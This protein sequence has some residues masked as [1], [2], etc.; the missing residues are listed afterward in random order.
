MI[1]LLVVSDSH[2]RY[3][4]LEEVLARQ[5]KLPESFRPTHLLHLGDGVNDVEKCHLAERMCTCLVKGNCDG[6]F[7]NPPVPNERVLELGGIKILMMHGH[8]RG[9]KGGDLN[10]VSYA[11]SIGADILLFGH[12]HTPVSYTLEKG[13]DLGETS[14]QKRLVVF[15]P[16]S[17]GYNGNFGVISLDG[18][19]ISCSHGVLN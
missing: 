16:G 9:V 4:K 13:T 6:F 7:Q 8:T 11:S 19:N 3:E 5:L 1:N 14:L 10:A 17:L 2:G 18:E 12:T 15:N